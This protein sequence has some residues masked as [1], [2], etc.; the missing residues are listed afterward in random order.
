MA[1][2]VTLTQCAS[3]V[4]ALPAIGEPFEQEGLSQ[5]F[6]LPLSVGGRWNARKK[7]LPARTQE[8]ARETHPTTEDTP[9]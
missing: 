6:P 3:G 4:Q 9:S 5:Q 2:D 1:L 8:E 7:W